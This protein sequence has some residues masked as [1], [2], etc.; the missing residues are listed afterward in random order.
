MTRIEHN[1]VVQSREIDLLPGQHLSGLKIYVDFGASLVRGQVKI[2]G[3]TL[4][5]NVLIFVSLMRQGEGTRLNG[6]ADSRGQFVIKNVPVGNYEA[7]MILASPGS[8]LPRG[9]PRQ[10]RQPIVVA[11][12]LDT[13]VIFTLDL[14][15]KDGPQ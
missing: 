9:F 8:D 6:Q 13:E 12:G 5:N 7:V 15:P 1:G 11:D 3:G 14:T 10:L 2:V 4:P